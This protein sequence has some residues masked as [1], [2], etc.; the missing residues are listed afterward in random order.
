MGDEDIS[1]ELKTLKEVLDDS[2]NVSMFYRT[3]AAENKEDVLKMLLETDTFRVENKRTAL[4]CEVLDD[5]WVFLYVKSSI[6]SY[7][8][9][10]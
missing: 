4:E 3:F 9:K 1:Q 10:L 5:S 2:D 7:F 8:R 6:N